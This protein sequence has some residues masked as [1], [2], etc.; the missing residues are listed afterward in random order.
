MILRKF[1]QDESGA[2]AIEYG[3]I[4]AAISVAIIVIVGTVG[5]NLTATFQ[6]VHTPSS[7]RR[8]AA[9]NRRRARGVPRALRVFGHSQ[10][11]GAF[12]VPSEY[13]VISSARG[14]LKS[15]RSK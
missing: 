2:T 6:S 10:V 4:A 13:R 8:F 1:L 15:G 9:A 7:D 14:A 12:T 5:D 3:L 11:W